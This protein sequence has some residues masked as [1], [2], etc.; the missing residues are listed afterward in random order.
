M[1][2]IKN[3]LS[4]GFYL[5]LLAI[6]ATVAA[7]VVYA[8]NGNH[9][10]YHDYNGKIVLLSVVV[11]ALEILLPVL[12]CL[13]GEKWWFD[14]FYLLPLALLGHIVVSFIAARVAS[15]GLILGSELEKGNV[16]AQSALSQAF[17]GIGLYFLAIVLSLI[18][19]F[20]SQTKEPA[21]KTCKE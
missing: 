6:A 13:I 16:V 4:V 21:D 2:N 3:R 5:S 19:S 15:A 7:T 11:I 20:M 8:I 1:R 18:R 9:A 14:I 12:V 10:Y 17:L